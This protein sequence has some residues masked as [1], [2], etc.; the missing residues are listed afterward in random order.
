MLALVI[1]GI[2][3]VATG[4]DGDK[5]QSGEAGN[6]AVRSPG[7][8][9]PDGP[10]EPDEPS[11]PD[12]RSPGGGETPAGE[13]KDVLDADEVRSVVF[14]GS[15]GTTKLDVTPYKV[16]KGGYAELKAAGIN[17]EKAPGLVPYY[18]TVSYTN[19]G[20]EEPWIPTWYSQVTIQSAPGERIT[21]VN[22]VDE[23][24]KCNF[25]DPNARGALT[26]GRSYK[27]CEIYLA[28]E[29]K[30]FYMVWGIDRIS[31]DGE[32]SVVWKLVD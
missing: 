26:V 11:L 19:R 3:F 4:D 20:G 5:G 15:G 31:G 1:G 28:P 32:A 2:V 10:T 12:M 8:E 24:A 27:P 7:A 30:P 9:S 6:S 16:Q 21:R 14:K 13:F 18:I 23:Y 29:D 22:Y 25:L 17:I